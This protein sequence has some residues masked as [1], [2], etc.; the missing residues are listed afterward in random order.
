M[1]FRL[2]RALRRPR[3]ERRSKSPRE[4]LTED[5]R[6]E[7][8]QLRASEV[9]L[10]AKEAKLEQQVRELQSQLAESKQTY[11]EREKSLRSFFLD[12]HRTKISESF[13]RG[14]AAKMG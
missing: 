5:F 13:H 14:R 3:Y 2:V 6:H 4:M 9:T 1:I 10:L 12:Y 11:R 8:V 7:L